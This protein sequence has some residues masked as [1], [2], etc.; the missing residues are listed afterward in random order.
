MVKVGK[1]GE[2]EAIALLTTII[3]T[4]IF[5]SYP[6]I[7]ISYGGSA[8]WMT[9]LVSGLTAM[10][11][12]WL[13]VKFVNRYPDTTFPETVENITGPYFGTLIVLFVLFPWL[14]ETAMTLRRFSEMIVVVALPETPIS[15]IMLTFVGSAA[16]VA[17]LGIQTIARACY[18]SFPFSLGAVLLITLLTYPSWN[19]DW[20]FPLLGKGIGQVIKYGVFHSSDYLELN[21]LYIIPLIFYT[22][23]VKR[24]G[25]KSIGIA[26][27]IFLLVVF[28]YTLTFPAAVG[29][30]PYLPLYMM[31][32][33]VY[34]GRFLQRIEAIFVLFWVISGYLWIS[35]GLFGFCATLTN[36]LKLPDCRPLIFPTAIIMMAVAFIPANMPDTV[37]FSDYFYR[38][39]SF[40]PVFGLPALLMFIAA[41][42][43]KGAGGSEKKPQA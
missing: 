40:I 27:L 8:A 37:F 34:L 25:Y 11:F 39:Y 38:E 16:I 10:A 12:F 14:I 17:Y 5:L 28:T 42:R 43:R 30:E 22:K 35:T 23:Q 4:K 36:L 21:V 32:R 18:L 31:A 6:T 24:I 13:I 2:S 3:T 7:M 15:I 20:L 19:M 41:I 9:V 1:I 26:L 29:E 33:S